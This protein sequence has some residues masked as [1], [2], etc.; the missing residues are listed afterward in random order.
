MKAAIV[1]LASPVGLTPHPHRSIHRHLPISALHHDM[2][3]PPNPLPSSNVFYPGISDWAN[4]PK[5]LSIQ[6]PRAAPQSLLPIP[7]LSD[8]APRDLV[9]A[10][11]GAVFSAAA[12]VFDKDHPELVESFIHRSLPSLNIHEAHV[13]ENHGTFMFM[14]QFPH[15]ETSELAAALVFRG[16]ANLE[17]WKSNA[18]AM[19]KTEDRTASKGL[20]NSYKALRKK[21]K[22]FV[23]G[24]VHDIEDRLVESLEDRLPGGL[25]VF[26]HSLGGAMASYAAEDIS[27]VYRER[28]PRGFSRQWLQVMSYG[29]PRE[30]TTIAEHATEY[31]KLRFVV[32]CDPV[33]SFPLAQESMSPPLD[34]PELPAEFSI[35]SAKYTHYGE[36]VYLHRTS[37]DEQFIATTKPTDFAATDDP[38]FFRNLLHMVPGHHI[39]HYIAALDSLVRHEGVQPL[40]TPES[41]GI[42]EHTSTEAKAALKLLRS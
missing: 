16:S 1:A 35:A 27:R 5:P 15:P 29:Q 30:F 7:G 3:V 37:A 38:K 39:L 6:L 21:V 14:V 17:N 25:F 41:R 13:F 28:F 40:L 33:P 36:A 12:Y 22:S 34:E 11:I 4:Q 26:G 24:L 32:E 18:M 20:Y 42:L 31:R 9:M 10:E 23:R 2:S 8:I 19:L